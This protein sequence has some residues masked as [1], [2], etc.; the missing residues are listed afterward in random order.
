M[1]D[2]TKYKKLCQKTNTNDIKKKNLAKSIEKLLLNNKDIML[3]KYYENKNN[4]H[5]IYYK[6]LD[7]YK[8]SKYPTNIDC[9]SIELQ[10]NVYVFRKHTVYF[11]NIISSTEITQD[12]FME[13]Y[14]KYRKFMDESVLDRQW[15]IKSIINDE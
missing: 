2:L 1:D 13:V 7:E 8:I 11:E 9:I 6:I 10:D 4:Y 15:K 14:T 12:I 5:Q 3:N